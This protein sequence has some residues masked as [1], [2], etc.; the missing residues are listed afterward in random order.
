MAAVIS[1]K[2]VVSMRK[3]AGSIKVQRMRQRI[4]LKLGNVFGNQLAEAGDIPHGRSR[5]AER[6]HLRQRPDFGIR[7]SDTAQ[8]IIL[9]ANHTELILGSAQGGQL[10]RAI[11]RQL[12]G[13]EAHVDRNSRLAILGEH[14]ACP[15]RATSSVVRTNVSTA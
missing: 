5:Q 9:P 11:G 12:L 13:Q 4:P 8:P 6:L 15:S 14:F 10:P 1:F 3:W 7:R 2:V